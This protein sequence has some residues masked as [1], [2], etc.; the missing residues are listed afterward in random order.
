MP[1]A[2]DSYRRVK[3]DRRQFWSQTIGPEAY[4][5]TSSGLPSCL[6]D[7]LVI[8]ISLVR[9]AADAKTLILALPN[10]DRGRAAVALYGQRDRFEP[11]V[12]YASM[13]AAWD[14]D[15]RVVIDAFGSRERLV[16]ALKEVSP[17]FDF[18]PARLAI[19]IPQLFRAVQPLMH[20]RCRCQRQG[21]PGRQ[22]FERTSG[23]DRLVE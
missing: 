8:S 5:I 13:I 12:V 19:R 4:P 22:G 1:S 15:H 14:H 21:Y 11:A 6:A 2:N 7:C 16:A 9:S 18:V 20:L 23:D 17:D 10:C 3:R